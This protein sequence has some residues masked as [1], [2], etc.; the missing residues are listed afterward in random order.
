MPNAMLWGLGAGIFNF[1]PYLGPIVFAVLLAAASIVHFDSLAYAFLPVLAFGVVNTLEGY[2]ISPM[3]YGRRLQLNPIMIFAALIIF[4][5]LWG[6]AGALMAVPLLVCFRILC[7]HVEVL[8]VPRA[9]LSTPDN[10]IEDG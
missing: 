4:A 7:D 5:W 2:I 8:R 9:F 10:G 3:I 6:V 1:V